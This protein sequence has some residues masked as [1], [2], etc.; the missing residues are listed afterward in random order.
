MAKVR[1]DAMRGSYNLQG[2][3]GR[4]KTVGGTPNVLGQGIMQKFLG[5]NPPA[6]HPRFGGGGPGNGLFPNRPNFGGGGNRPNFGGGFAQGPGGL[7]NMPHF[8]GHFPGGVGFPHPGG[9]GLGNGGQNNGNHQGG[10]NNGNGGGNGGPGSPFDPGALDQI[11]NGTGDYAQ[12]MKKLG[13]PM[14]PQFLAER[15]GLVNNRDSAL[16]QLLNQFNV[17]NAQLDQ[18]SMLG[19]RAIAGNDAARGVYGS[20]IMARDNRL[21]G[22][23]VAQQ[24]LGLQTGYNEGSLGA[25][26]DYRS[27]MMS[28]LSELASRLQGQSNLPLPN[29]GPWSSGMGGGGMHQGNGGGGQHG[30][31]RGGRR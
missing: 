19:Q 25:S 18:Q 20:G 13:M 12:L 17:G 23:D 1:H 14:D 7:H 15:T 16:S 26:Q 31:R 24:R 29:W 27:Q 9:G 5:G 8:Q 21:L 10:G 28:S 11:L 4:S 30:G 22:N 6:K 2:G 3:N